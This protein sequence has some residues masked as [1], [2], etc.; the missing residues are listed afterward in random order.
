MSRALQ[1]L[2]AA[3]YLRKWLILGALIGVVAGVGAVVLITAL[4]RANHF[5]LSFMAGY[6]P[7]RRGRSSSRSNEGTSCTSRSRT[8]SSNRVTW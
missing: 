7:P 8:R 2:K 3:S 5:F 4:K 1:R 6:T